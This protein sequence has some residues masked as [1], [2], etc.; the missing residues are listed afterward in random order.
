MNIEFGTSNRRRT[1]LIYQ[2]YKY[3]EKQ[4]PNTI[5]HWTC[6]HYHQT[7]S[8][9]LTIMSG[10]E[11]INKPKYHTCN[12]KPRAT[13]ARRSKTK[14]E[15]LYALTSTYY[16]PFASIL[17][18]IQKKHGKANEFATSRDYSK[19]LKTHFHADHMENILKI[20]KNTRTL[21]F[22]T[23]RQSIRS[24]QNKFGPEKNL[25]PQSGIRTTQFLRGQWAQIMQL[26]AGIIE[27]SCFL[28]AV[29]RTFGLPYRSIAKMLYSISSMPY[30][31]WL[32]TKNN[33][34]K[35]LINWML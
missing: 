12:F 14:K 29:I 10:S 20:T 32:V 23:I 31:L 6:R 30:R 9:S 35:N 3:V 21:L 7:K 28:A 2:G 24:E 34:A 27:S 4:R 22:T 1:T 11:I 17:Q 18:E 16:V 15:T 33:R 19:T 5:T 25:N 13:E 8:S 26:K